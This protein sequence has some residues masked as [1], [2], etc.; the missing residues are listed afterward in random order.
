MPTSED[1]SDV[2]IAIGRAMDRLGIPFGIFG[3]YAIAT[4]G[5]P[6]ESKDIDC[7]VNCTKEW[8]VSNLSENDGFK[9]MGN[10]RQDI[11]TFLWGDRNVLVEFFPSKPPL[12][13]AE[14][15]DAD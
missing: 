4:L 6:R 7:A 3:G 13:N 1:L 2:A 15:L 12:N 5:G 14:K 8:L 10:K 9:S 11:V